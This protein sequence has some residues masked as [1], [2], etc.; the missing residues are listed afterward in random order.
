MQRL[1]RLSTLLL[2]TALYAAGHFLWYY[3][4]P[5]GQSPALDGQENLIIAAQIRAGSLP[6]EPFF[7]AM[8]YPALLAILPVSPM[9]LG[10]CCHLLNA[11]LAYRLGLAFWQSSK[12]AALTGALVGLNPVLLHFATDPLDITLATSCFLGAALLALQACQAARNEGPSQRA[13]AVRFA[14]A[15]LL[16][17]LAALARPHFFAVLIPAVAALSLATALRRIRWTRGLLFAS[18]ALAPILAYGLVQVSVSGQFAILPWQGPYNLWISNKP[19]ANGLYYQQS[20]NFH[21][22]G[23]HENPNRLESIELF[24]QATGHEG[25]IDERGDYWREQ[26]KTA[27][28]QDPVRWLKLMA[29]KGYAYLNTFEQYNN[30]TYS[31]HKE[32]SPALRYNPISWGLLLVA[33]TLGT[34]ALRREQRGPAIALGLAFAC[35]AAGVLIYMA[36]GRFRLPMVPL[37]ALLAG[38]LPSLL[39]QWKTLSKGIQAAALAA[40]LLSGGLT[41]S[42]FAGVHSDRTAIQDRLL[43]ADAAARLGRD[44]EAIHWAQEALE[45]DP[46]RQSAQRI[47]LISRYNEIASAASEPTPE[48]WRP[49]ASLA[50][51]IQLQDPQLLFV[52]GVAFWNTQQPQ[53]AYENWNLALQQ[54]GLQASSSLAALHYTSR[55]PE[56]AQAAQELAPHL[57]HNSHPLLAFAVLDSLPPEQQA[58]LA[59]QLGLPP[60]RL[61]NLRRLMRR[62]LPRH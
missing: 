62:I 28:A 34:F 33:A 45:H 39:V 37:L 14:G 47:L 8:L 26:T 55:A 57:D 6:A 41:F 32:L 10:Y 60:D 11:F 24:R 59:A 40:L 31:F 23:E 25:S 36:S 5:L 3:P 15:G 20:L 7:R 13:Q 49:L 43:L 46:Q 58:P 16:L 21:Y 19:G 2:L 42:R 56:A 54:F 50:G 27:I 12:S 1:T 38:G 18:G 44:A 4:T 52:K 22:T 30:K 51:A 53:A 35:F 48:L 29:F 9:L 61:E 17:A